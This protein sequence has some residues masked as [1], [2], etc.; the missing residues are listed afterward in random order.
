MRPP[1]KPE[2]SAAFGGNIEGGIVADCRVAG[3]GVYEK[4]HRHPRFDNLAAEFEGL[5]RLARDSS[6]RRAGAN[7]LFHCG[8]DEGSVAAKH[9]ILIRMFRQQRHAET[10]LGPRRIHPAEN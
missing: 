5:N 7:E 8:R 2:M 1:A 10:K 3:R 4:M 6:R 9:P